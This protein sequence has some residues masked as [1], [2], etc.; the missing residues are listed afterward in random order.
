MP[1]TEGPPECQATVIPDVGSFCDAPWMAVVELV[2]A[3]HPLV[4]IP[5]DVCGK[6]WEKENDIAII[7]GGDIFHLQYLD[8][9]KVYANNHKVGV[10]A[11][12]NSPDGVKHRP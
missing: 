12:R 9:I 5:W 7:S 8:L 10:T 2:H 4:I 1:R 11:G 3:I 6:R